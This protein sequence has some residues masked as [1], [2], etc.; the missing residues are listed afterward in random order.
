MRSNTRTRRAFT[1][2]ELLVVIAII[3]ILAAILFPVFA[4]ARASARAISC[5]SN[6]K[7]AALGALMY[8]QDYD[9]QIP[10]IDN[11]GSNGYGCC[12]SGSCLPDWGRAG[13]DPNEADAM[14]MGVIQPYTKNRQMNYCPEAGRTPW[15]TA[16][17]NPAID[18]ESY[19]QALDTR[20]VYQS[21]YSQMAVNILLT[22]FGPG[23]S[24]ANCGKGGIYHAGQ[25]AMAGW[26]RPAELILFTGDSVWGE[27]INGDPS[28]TM[29]VGNTSVWPAYTNASKN[30]TNYGGYAI[31]TQPGWTWYVH[32]GTARQGHFTDAGITRFDLGINSGFANIAMADG[33]AKAFKQ[34]NLERC[35]FNTAGNVWTYPYWDP[36]Y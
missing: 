29:A 9:E 13:T 4:Q 3:A 34:N 27:G 20:G 26:Q 19:V 15:P 22:E 5:I 33:H 32:K 14:F 12:P 18:G 8:T 23:S 35:D 11:N 1:L 2:I 10:M 16:I 31:N 28:P 21:T 17:P 25:G 24:W 6:V 7:Q 36:R 30:C